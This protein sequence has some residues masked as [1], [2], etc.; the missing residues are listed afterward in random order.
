VVGSGDGTEIKEIQK[1]GIE[2][3]GITI[4]PPE[5]KFAR[6][7]GLDVKVM[8]M[9][10]LKFEPREFDLIYS[11]DCFKQGMAPVIVWGELTR[12]ASRYILLSEPDNRWAH[13][14]HNHLL[15]TKNQFEVLAEKFGWRLIKFWKLDHGYVEQRNFLF[16]RVY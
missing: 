5:A 11:K 12:V 3:K 10:Q 14:A 4:S 9:H 16:E 15:L 6:Q 1:K 8:D 2:V 7:Q 13:R